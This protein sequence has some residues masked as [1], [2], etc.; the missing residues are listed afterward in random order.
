MYNIKNTRSHHHCIFSVCKGSEKNYSGHGTRIKPL[1]WALSLIFSQGILSAHAEDIHPDSSTGQYEFDNSMLV[2][3]AKDQNTLSRFTK[4]NSVEPGNYQVDIFVNGTFFNRQSVLFAAS[5]KGDVY[6]CF[7]RDLLIATGIMPSSLKAKDNSNQCLNLSSEVEGAS[8][9]F[10]FARLRI[11]LLVPQANMARLAR[12]AVPLESLSAGETALFVN[13]DTNFYRTHASGNNNSDSTYVGLNSGLNLGLWQLRQQSSYSRYTTSN[14]PDTSSWKSI[15]TYLQR[16]LPSMNS[17]LTLGDSYT[18]GTLFSSLGFRG[19]QLETDERMIPESQRGYA[20]TIRGIAQTTAKV[21]VTQSG[22]QIYQTTVAP[23]AFVIDDLYPTSY[24]GDLVVEVQEADGRVSSFTVPFAAVPESM[25]PGR[26]H[27]SLSA[28]QVRDIGNSNDMFA[29]VTLQHG[30][31]NTVTGNV[32]ARVSDGYQALLAGAVLAT[33]WGALG[34]NAVYSRANMFGDSLNGWRLGATYSK[35]FIPTAT[36][37]ALA[38]YRY[39]TEGYRDLADVLGV[40]DAQQRDGTW[41]SSTYEQRNQFVVTLSQSLGAYGQAYISGSTSSYRNGRSRDTQ[42]QAGY[43]HHWGRLNYNLSFSRQQIGR[44]TYG[45][46]NPNDTSYDNTNTGRT[47][48]AFMISFSLPLGEGTRSPILTTGM[49]HQSG[50]GGHDTWQSSLTGTL[51][52]AQNT[53]YSLNG[54]YDSGGTGYSEGAALT[55]QLPFVTLG[56]SLSHGK[57]YTQYGASARGAI[58][59]HSGGLTLGPYL[60]DTFALVEADGAAGAEVTSGMG[61]KINGSGYA[62]VPSLIP[63][64]Y[65]DVTLDAKGVKNPNAEL[66]D[67]QQRVAPYA[68]AVVKMKFKTIEGYALLIRLISGHPLPLGATVFNSK[69]AAIGLVGQGNQIYARAAETRGKL[70]VKW[71]DSAAEQ[72]TIQYDISAE[73]LNQTLYRL[74]LPCSGSSNSV[75]EQ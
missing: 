20:P 7:S 27:V 17:E 28:G 43:S 21:T 32:G 2:G 65:N 71:G 16:P 74:A 59:G 75:N 45:V 67:N 70:F 24:Q 8:T 12:G 19:V 26:S 55:Q 61:S 11:D 3:S 69:Q 18:S 13:Y 14:G 29:D 34:A 56:G 41:N 5:A 36:T 57:D 33:E 6:P 15:R 44:T 66:V 60:G 62:I 40:R 39:S 42:Y 68:G 49:S 23:G 54:A 35:T 4:A 37:L 25:R 46:Q 73:D 58:V 48:N 31:T 51:G 30:L 22:T 72:C 53:T 63:Y 52:E 10:D 64:A 50:D 9:H 47:E 1:A 38:G